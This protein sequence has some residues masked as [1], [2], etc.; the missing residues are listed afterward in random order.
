MVVILIMT[1][2]ALIISA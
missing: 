1:K 2:P